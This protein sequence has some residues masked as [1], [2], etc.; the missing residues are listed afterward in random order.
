MRKKNSVIWFYSMFNLILQ[1][2][3]LEESS[4]SSKSLQKKMRKDIK[5]MSTA[6]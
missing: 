3:I 4:S 1:S 2:I 5:I 6:F